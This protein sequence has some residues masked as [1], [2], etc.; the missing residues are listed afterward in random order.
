MKNIQSEVKSVEKLLTNNRYHLDF[1]QR[2]YSWEKK[3]VSELVLD[4]KAKFQKSYK[5]GHA[6]KEVS[7]YKD[8]FL[9]SI[10]IGVKKI[11]N[12]DRYS[13]VDGQQRLTTLTLFLIYLNNLQSEYIQCES[14]KAKIDGLI[15]QD[16]HGNQ[17]FVLDVE[18][19]NDCMEALFIGGKFDPPENDISVKNICARYSDFEEIFELHDKAALPNFI[20]WLIEKVYFV[21]IT[22]TSDDAFTIFETM[23]D[24]GLSLTHTEM[25]KGYLLSNIHESE[26]RTK[27]NEVWKKHIG[28]LV[29]FKKGADAECIKAWLRSQYAEGSVEKDFEE[30]GSRFHRWVRDNSSRLKLVND[31]DFADFIIKEFSFFAENFLKILHACEYLTSDLECIYFNAQH[32]FT[33]QFPLLLAH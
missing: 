17:S 5:K 24:R 8:Y 21:K 1:Y 23:N 32:S 14:K 20:D 27:A 13:I 30:I 7:N 4:L 11:E 9:G 28:I 3:H 19:R 15:K 26:L 22:A 2:E 25:L 18:N 33:L 31:K 29:N 6:R 16:K 10:I 12:Y